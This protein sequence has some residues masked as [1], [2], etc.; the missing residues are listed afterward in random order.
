MNKP[1]KPSLDP[2]EIYMNAESYRLAYIT[3]RITGDKDPNFMTA[4]A[5]PH[6]VLSAFA[7]E[8]YF[9]CLLC[10]EGS[11]V[12]PTHNLKAL[13]R[14]L[15]PQ[16]RTRVEQLWKRH[17]VGLEE[18]WRMIEQTTNTPVP[19]DFVTLLAMSSNAFQK[20]RYVHEDASG[21]F[22][23]GDLPPILRTIILD[24]R[25]LWA[26]LRHAPP[27]SLPREKQAVG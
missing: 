9:K 11:K 25:P 1:V 2:L 20:L 16:T 8:L 26:T 19:R 3:L 17:A 10:L 13:F 7:T 21:S 4:V 18:M 23:V 27:T 24:R 14:E 22:F 5:T 15:A 12:M 6:M